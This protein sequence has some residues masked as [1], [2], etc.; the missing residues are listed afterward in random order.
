MAGQFVG[1]PVGGGTSDPLVSGG[2]SRT[3][4]PQAMQRLLR[5]AVRSPDAVRDDMPSG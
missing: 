2:A 3:G 5:T 1:G 4:N